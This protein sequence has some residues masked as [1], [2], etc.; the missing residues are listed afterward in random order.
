MG[1]L[2]LGWPVWIGLVC[3]DLEAQ[4]RFYAEVLGLREADA[5]DDWVHFDVGSGTLE[6]LARNADL[7]QYAGSGFAPG[8]EVDDIRA[9]VDEL[10]ARGVDRVTEV[11]GG[12]ESGQY[13]CYFKDGEGRLFEIAQ[14]I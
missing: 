13:W 10:V 4:R 8:F 1:K 5:G 2:R 7:P 3:D 11:E 6:L 9:A 12:P 14:K